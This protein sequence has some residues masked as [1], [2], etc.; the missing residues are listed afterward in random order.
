MSVCVGV[1]RYGS[2]CVGEGRDVLCVW[3]NVCVCGFG[4]GRVCGVGRSKCV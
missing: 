1:L 2:V 4:N 3:V